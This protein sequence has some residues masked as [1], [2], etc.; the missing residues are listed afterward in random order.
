MNSTTS[1]AISNSTRTTNET[2]IQVGQVTVQTQATDAKG[3]SQSVGGELKGQLKQL[4]A[5]TSSG[6]AR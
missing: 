2:N 1:S 4:E 6:V 5:E 3:I